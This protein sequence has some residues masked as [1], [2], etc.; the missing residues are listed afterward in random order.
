[1]KRQRDNGKGFKTFSGMGLVSWSAK[2]EDLSSMA[3]E[4]L[5]GVKKQCL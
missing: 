5:M 4:T 2:P 1:M 3:Q